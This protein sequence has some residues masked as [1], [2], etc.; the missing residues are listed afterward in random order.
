MISA[1]LPVDRDDAV[2][3]DRHVPRFVHAGVEAGPLELV[4]QPVRL[5]PEEVGVVESNHVVP[6]RAHRRRRPELS[7]DVGQHRAERVAEAFFG[8]VRRPARSISIETVTTTAERR[9]RRSRPH[10][11]WARSRADASSIQ[12]TPVQAIATSISVVVPH[13]HSVR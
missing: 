1:V 5:A 9:S 2:L 6:V 8:M 13:A 12:A 3:G 4:D 11:P 7:G 10:A